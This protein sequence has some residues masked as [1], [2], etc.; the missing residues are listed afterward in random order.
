MD[1][2]KSVIS[3]SA[4]PPTPPEKEKKPL[5]PPV[6]PILDY[7][8]STN[9][10]AFRS[11]IDF[12][13]FFDSIPITDDRVGDM[14]WSYAEAKR[15]IDEHNEKFIRNNDTCWLGKPI[16]TS[17]QDA[18]GRNR[19]LRMDDFNTVYRDEIYPRIQELIKNSKAELEFPT[20]SYNDRGF[21]VFDFSRASLGLVPIYK[22]Y[23]LKKG[24]FVQGDECKF[25]SGVKYKLKEDESPVVIVPKL[26][27]DDKKLTKKIYQEVYDGKNIFDL[28]KKYK[29]RIGGTESI[30]S[31]IKKVYQ[32]K[33]KKPKPRNAIKIFVQ[34]GY[35]CNIPADN[36]CGSAYKYNEESTKWT[37]YAAIGIAEILSSMGY[38]VSIIAIYGMYIQGGVRIGND[39]VEGM[40]F[41][42]ITLKRFEDTLD[43]PNL[44]YYISDASFF[45]IKIFDV[46]IKSCSYYKEHLSD[47][48]NRS[49]DIAQMKNFVFGEYA[50]RDK[51][52]KK[53]GEVDPTA[54]MLYY[55]LADVFSLQELREIILNIAS[56]VVNENKIAREILGIN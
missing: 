23:S 49:C 28:L 50:K 27:T 8:N 5:T 12:W 46:I 1:L 45:R 24:E 26:L 13:E 44:L 17:V 4:Q 29:V 48:L 53:S 18:L 41:F 2:T 39:L 51:I 6:Q 47:G 43:T 7:P 33:E 30:N 37:G 22:Y 14:S 54:P 38:Q 35:N 3:E 16:P 11:M 31:S 40:R 32:L 15:Y 55:I 19:Y 52:Y 34:V 42:G 9:F 20:I 21:G 10:R 36:N 25:L 56:D